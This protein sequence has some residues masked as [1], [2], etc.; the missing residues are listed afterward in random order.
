MI[1]SL[2]LKNWKSHSDTALEFGRGTNI[3]VGIMGSGKSSVLEGICFAFFGTFPGAQR[4]KVKLSEAV[5]SLPPG[6]DSA[7][8]SLAFEWEGEEY[9][10]KRTVK[11]KGQA[12]AELRRGGALLAVEPE[13]V[14]EAIGRILKID[15]ALFYRAVYA[16]QNR[17]DYFLSL[18]PRERK[19]QMD[20]LLGIDRFEAARANATTAATYIRRMKAQK[21]AEI[22]GLDAEALSSAARGA[23]E[24][25]SRL[26]LEKGSAEKALAAA[27]EAV[28]SAETAFSAAS[29][30]KARFDSLKLNSVSLKAKISEMRGQAEAFALKAGGA[31]EGELESAS[32]EA[33]A[34][35]SALKARCKE[36]SSRVS[37]LKGREGSLRT[38]V[39]RAEKAEAAHKQLS[40]SL[41]RIEGGSEGARARASA[42]RAQKDA[43]RAKAA[44][45]LAEGKQCQSALDALGKAGCECP[46]CARPIDDALRREL[47]GQR[48]ARVSEARA[49]TE[50]ISGEEKELAR[51]IA[52]EEKDY[53]EAC[54]AEGRLSGLLEEAS[55]AADSRMQ[56]AAVLAE[57]EEAARGQASLDAQLEKAARDAN[58]VSERLQA[59]RQASSLLKRAGDAGAELS[60]AEAELASLKFEPEAFEGLRRDCESRRGGAL[61]LEGELKLLSEKAKSCA[62]RLSSASEALSAFARKAEESKAYSC[63]L[64]SAAVLQAGL[65]ETQ[66][67]LRSELI[68]AINATMC[69]LWP[70]IY[71]YG[72]FS[73]VRL[74]AGESDY[75]L[76]LGRDGAWI[77]VEGFAS[78]GERSCA[79]LC[80]RIAFA[81]VMVPNLR[82]LV[83]DEPT[84]NLD[85]KGISSLS[86]VLRERIPKIVEQ[87]FVITHD[88]SL[89]EAASARVY[90]LERDKEANG[91]ARAVEVS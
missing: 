18:D 3:L 60:R 1:R 19:K 29:E 91:P 30:A 42:L 5:S 31:G 87:V 35:Q 13:K 75:Q 27:R 64:E 36:L 37:S 70:E 67:A 51:R 61:K 89:K 54:A 62:E 41:S 24:E 15:Y 73:G 2:R 16:E 38:S 14:T 74:E 66:A 86:E 23:Q 58:S 22:A 7:E 81:M 26:A 12:E 85:A 53:A 25:S 43:L 80:L 90:R 63:A 57:L 4:K 45:L 56:L 40:A 49:G 32:K 8:V 65:I 84:H 44:E 83:L 11:R 77:P 68:E 88:E 47:S 72:D 20:E 39:A 52:L 50:R 78:G 71:P 48:A 59:A 82:W 17:L 34:A 10:V 69:G 28:R 76:E 9:L 21:D 79:L 46:V 6:A 55:E 33:E